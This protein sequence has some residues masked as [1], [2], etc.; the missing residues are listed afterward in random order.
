MYGM[1]GHHG[2]GAHNTYTGAPRIY[3]DVHLCI[4]MHMYICI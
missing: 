1:Y 4:Y 3:I 2:H